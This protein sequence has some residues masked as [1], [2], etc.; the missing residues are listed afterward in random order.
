MSDQSKVYIAGIGM[1]TAVGG[2]AEMTAAAVR[3]GISG[4]QVSEYKNWECKPITMAM[5]PDDAFPEICDELDTSEEM[6]DQIA[7]MLMMSHVALEEVMESY[8]GTVPLPLILS[9]PEMDEDLEVPFSHTFFD[10]LTTQSDIELDKSNCRLLGLGRAGVIN[11]IDVAGKYLNQGHDYVLVGGVD[12]YQDYDLILK[13]TE[14]DRVKAEDSTDGFIPGEAA[15]FLLLTGKVEL[16][17]KFG[18]SILSLASPGLSQEPGHFSSEVTYTGDGLA[19]S[20]EVALSNHAG[21]AISCVY[22][23]LNG[24][25]FWA[26]EY[27]V[28]MLR[29]KKFMEEDVIHEHPAD[30]YGDLG[31][32]TG[33]VLIGLAGL[34]LVRGKQVKSSLICSSSDNAY[35]SA[36]CMSLLH[37]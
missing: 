11:G 13:L 36:V 1:I 4:Y 16:A 33:A 27:G 20:F 8:P 37:V 9:G 25:N 26:K 17:K 6:S 10:L 30:C 7:R 29:N 22:S 2:T 24:E 5:V 34:S 35:R 18:G 23:S 31:A 21:Q 14:Q 3:A 32:A 12:S 19:K 28:A 15:C